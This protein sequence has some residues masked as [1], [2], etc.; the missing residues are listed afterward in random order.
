MPHLAVTPTP[1]LDFPVLGGL[2]TLFGM[3]CRLVEVEPF[4][5][6]KRMLASTDLPPGIV[7]E[8][9]NI[10]TAQAFY[11]MLRS[12]KDVGQLACICARV[13]VTM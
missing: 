10:Q 12:S 6:M 7:V 13:T 4:A 8:V 1:A 3:T 9:C 11:D 5:M 2:H